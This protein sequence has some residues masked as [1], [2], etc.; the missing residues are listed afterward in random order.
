MDELTDFKTLIRWAAAGTG[1]ARE[2]AA[3]ALV[4][5]YGPLIRTIIKRYLKQGVTDVSQEVWLKI[6]EHAQADKIRADTVD[7]FVSLLTRVARNASISRQR[8]WGAKCRGRGH[9]IAGGDALVAVSAKQPRPSEI[10]G[11]E[12]QAQ[13]LLGRLDD[14]ERNLVLLRRDGHSNKEIGQEVGCSEGAVEARFR[15]LRRVLRD[16]G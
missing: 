12:E 9:Q 2:H 13:V 4:E 3:R 16:G 14:R 10:V 7:E 15:Q 11:S 1:A 5:L 8:Y 6:F